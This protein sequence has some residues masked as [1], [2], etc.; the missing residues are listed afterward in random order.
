MSPSATG[1]RA[2]PCQKA[3]RRLVR[4]KIEKRGAPHPPAAG[5]SPG[6]LPAF[7]SRERQEQRQSELPLP[8]AAAARHVYLHRETRTASETSKGATTASKLA[9]A[10]GQHSLESSGRLTW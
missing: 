5:A 7:Y 2:L 3:S 9:R 10:R 1:N 6:K 4:K 8:P